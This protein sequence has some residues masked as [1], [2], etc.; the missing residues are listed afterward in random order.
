MADI[1]EMKRVH[2]NIDLLMEERGIKND[3]ELSKLLGWSQARLSQRINGN[4]S[5]GTL[6]HI[7]SVFGV[8]VKE[9]L[10]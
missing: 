9:L 6:E 3:K 8:S 4:L 2:T 10:R 7:A 5:L 1:S